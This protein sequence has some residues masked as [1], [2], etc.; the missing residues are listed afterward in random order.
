MTAARDPQTERLE[1]AIQ[2]EI[3][4]RVRSTTVTLAWALGCMTALFAVAHLLY[5]GGPLGLRLGRLAALSSLLTFAIALWHTRRP[6]PLRAAHALQALVGAVPLLNSSAHLFWTL[7]P[8]QTTNL[9]LFQLALGFLMLSSRW[10]AV[11]TLATLSCVA[12]AYQR[13]GGGHGWDHFLFMLGSGT[14]G[15]LMIHVIHLGSVR[16]FERERILSDW[17]TQARLSQQET[18]AHLGHLAAVE[19]DAAAFLQSCV[20]A[21]RATLNADWVSFERGGAPPAQLGSPL[22]AAVHAETAR[23][24]DTDATLTVHLHAAP[25]TTITPFLQSVVHLTAM[26]L[27]RAELEERRI[28]AERRLLHA[29]RMESVALLAGGVAHDFNNLLTVILGHADVLRFRPG[30][31]EPARASLEQIVAAS[32][33]AARLTQ[34]LLAFSRK[35]PLQVEVFDVR[36]VV[37]HLET[38]LRRTIRENIA[39]EVHLSD[40][41]CTVNADRAQLEQVVMNLVVN[42]RDAVSA[43]GLITV[44]VARVQLAALPEQAELQLPAGAYVM[45]S[46]QDNG[47]G[48]EQSVLPH[49]F[50]PFFTT[51]SHDRGTGLGLATVYGI[52]HQCG[53]TI[54]VKSQRGMGTTFR[55]Y[56]PYCDPATHASAQAKPR[57]VPAQRPQRVLVAEDNDAV[58]G[59]VVAT[60]RDAHYQVLEASSGA[61]ALRTSRSHAGPIELLLTDVVMP[62]VS[63]I[64]L[65]RQLLRERPDMQLMLMSG[66]LGD[67]P[68]SS[69]LPVRPAPRLLQKPFTASELLAAVEEVL[70]SGA[71]QHSRSA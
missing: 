24:N 66:H 13:S 62:E 34:Q 40:E 52:V 21:V 36:N 37:S 57:I 23:A 14:V 9:A 56:M 54:A 18:V 6:P 22:T 11:Y 43:G 48:I 64:E 67:E 15:A 69:A 2:H 20:A 45:L 29:Q 50:E 61:E 46:V 59:V 49:I 30:M 68:S 42:A 55:V 31:D 51:K 19:R 7:E 33:L 3:D 16:R 35:Q 27:R 60:L 38:M 1:R 53:G 8:A 12:V 41:P 25:P 10:F 4:R 17:Q 63:G 32:Q 71:V 26:S 70:Q 5:L 65:A 28:D 47:A 58:R 44:R 39:V